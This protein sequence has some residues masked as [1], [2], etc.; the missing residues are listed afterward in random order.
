MNF[1]DLIPLA[2]LG[3]SGLAIG[4]LGGL[5]FYFIKDTRKERDERA[6]EAKEQHASTMQTLDGVKSVLDYIARGS[7][8]PTNNYTYK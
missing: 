7:S 8:H 4:I 2:D 3:I 5:L 1:A 6:K